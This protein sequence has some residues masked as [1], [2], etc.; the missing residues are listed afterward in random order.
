MMRSREEIIEGVYSKEVISKGS[1]GIP[2]KI[3]QH[4]QYRPV[5]GG[6]AQLELLLD[7]REY[8]SIL[9]AA[10][11]IGEAVERGIERK[12]KGKA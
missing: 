10:K 9:V 5:E 8:L 4:R 3:L 7:I 6:A 2:D 1:N 12:R 11:E